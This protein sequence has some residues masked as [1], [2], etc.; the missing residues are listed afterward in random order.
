MRHR[1]GQG[2]PRTVRGGATGG[3]PGPGRRRASTVN[4]WHVRQVRGRGLHPRDRSTTEDAGGDIV[5]VPLQPVARATRSAGVT[6]PATC[7]QLR[8][9]RRPPRSP[10]PTSPGRGSGGWCC[11]TDAKPRPARRPVRR[12]CTGRCARTTRCVASVGTRPS[13][14]PTTSTVTSVPS[15][16]RASIRSSHAERQTEAVEAG[17][18]VR[19]RR[20][21]P[22]RPQAPL[23]GPAPP[24]LRPCP[25]SLRDQP[26]HRG[27]ARRSPRRRGMHRR[28]SRR[29]RA[30]CGSLSPW[31]VRVHTTGCPAVHSPRAWAS[32]PGDT[33]A[34]DAG[35]TNTPVR[36]R[37]CRC[38]ARICSSVTASIRPPDSSRASTAWLPRSGVAD[39]DGGGD[40][41]GVGRPLPG[42]SAPPL[43]LES[44]HA[45]GAAWPAPVVGV[46]AVA[47]PVGRD[48]AGVAD[49]KARGCRARRPARRRSRRPRV[50]WPSMRAGLTELTSSTG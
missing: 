10:P 26:E 4:R 23:P 32:E 44:P 27:S 29:A 45:R 1:G 34:A 14:S 6:E 43:G 17:T 12:R 8:G 40:R 47:L 19:A 31:P 22:R 18:E 30:H 25:A 28:I 20:G 38:A 15:A 39:P 11:G 2:H 21:G 13:P 5:R 48:V 33:D 16:R 50:F 3:P 49:R 42:R 9:H 41:L 46:L 37:Q 35:S 24:R 7:R 36:V